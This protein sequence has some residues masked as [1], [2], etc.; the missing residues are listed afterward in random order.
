MEKFE[1]FLGWI[2]TSLL[3]LIVVITKILFKDIYSKLAELSKT[4]QQILTL[5]NDLDK[6]LALNENNDQTVRESVVGLKQAVDNI[7][8][9]IVLLETQPPAPRKRRTNKP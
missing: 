7:N 2:A 1:H 5:L 6:R 3:G 9:H 8:A 4:D